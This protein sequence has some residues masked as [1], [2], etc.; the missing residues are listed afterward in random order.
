MRTYPS[1]T[2]TI[3]THHL[4]EET[5]V[6]L[7]ALNHRVETPVVTCPDERAGDEHARRVAALMEESK[8]YQGVCGLV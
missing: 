5:A 7:V 8:R 6:R 3:E 4:A 2:A 1:D